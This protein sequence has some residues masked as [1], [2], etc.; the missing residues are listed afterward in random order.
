MKKLLFTFCLSL[1]FLFTQAQS[2]EELKSMQAEKQGMIADLQ[3]QI[4]AANA[5][6][7]GIQKEI[8]VLSGWR[9]GL[10]GLIGFD[11]NNSNGWIAN[12]NPDASSS[13]L[14]LGV[15]AYALADKEKSFWHNKLNLQKA[16]S[17]VNTSKSDDGAEEDGLFDNGTV[18]ILNLSSLAGYKL[19]D[20][21][22]LSGLGELNTSIENFLKPGTFDIGV[23][24][25]WLPIENMTV[26]I[27]PLNYHVAWPA[28]GQGL[29]TKGALG[30]KFRVDYF[31]DFNVSG[32]A[33]NWS[34]TLTSFV[35]YSDVKQMVVANPDQ[36]IEAREAG[37]FEY[38]WLNTLSFE[39]WNG[40]GVGVGFGLR[41]SDLESPDLQSFT[42]LGLSYGF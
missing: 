7:D 37:L 26:V 12:P 17:D 31:Q 1:S 33:V 35:P 2:L 27:H 34:T 9:K 24:A 3:A 21:F 22:A 13:A 25:T 39:V 30:T 16:W 4:D 6:L 23:G 18:D 42:S 29:E 5:E 20:K 15:N 38:T 19:S 36:G 28:D 14:N 40:I 41:N 11:L 32:K 10:N 8:D